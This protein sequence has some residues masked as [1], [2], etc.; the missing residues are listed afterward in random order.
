MKHFLLLSAAVLLTGCSAKYTTNNIQNRSENLVRDEPVVISVP[1]DGAYEG[2]AYSG[3]GSAT[4]SAVRA[5]FLKHSDT[6]TVLDDCADITCLKS[7]S[8]TKRGYYVVP[9][10]LHWEERA[11][12]WS[13][14]PDQ[15]EV[16][17]TVYDIA[18]DERLASTILAGKSKLATFGGD[19]PQD[20]L[21]KPV[22]DYV[23]SLY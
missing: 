20:L 10:I 23:N 21:P 16:K 15:I 19:H 17:I 5:A 1:A 13:G 7:H 6:V 12:E 3:S 9:Q 2:H 8:T 4:A 11:T 14:I 18:S 22:N